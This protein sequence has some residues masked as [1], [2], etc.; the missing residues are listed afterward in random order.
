MSDSKFIVHEHVEYESFHCSDCSIA[1]GELIWV[2]LGPLQGAW[3]TAIQ[4]KVLAEIINK[5][6][7]SHITRTTQV[8]IPAA[9]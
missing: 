7:D 1:S 6:A 2:G 4:A 5:V 3:L 9:A 8:Q